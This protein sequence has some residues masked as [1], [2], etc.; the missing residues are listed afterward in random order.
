MTIKI[1]TTVLISLFVVGKILGAIFVLRIVAR[2][3]KAGKRKNQSLKAGDLGNL[4]LD[5]K[6]DRHPKSE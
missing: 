1:P 5:P 2:M 4:S 6:N 3:R